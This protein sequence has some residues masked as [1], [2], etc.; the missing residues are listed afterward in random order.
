L[1]VKLSIKFKGQGC[2]Q[3]F[4]GNPSHS[5][6]APRAVCDLTVLPAARHRWTCLALTPTIQAGTRRICPGG[7]E[8]WVDLAVGYIPRWFTRRRQS[9]I[10]VVTTW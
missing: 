1:G 2:V 8:G 7:M 4:I 6:G 3:L 5:Y 9:P 10:Q